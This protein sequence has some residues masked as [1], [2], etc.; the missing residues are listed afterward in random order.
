MSYVVMT[1]SLNVIAHAV[2]NRFMGFIDGL[3]TGILGLTS[4]CYDYSQCSC[5]HK[6]G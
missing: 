3:L 6:N 1:S 2:T 4:I 5:Q